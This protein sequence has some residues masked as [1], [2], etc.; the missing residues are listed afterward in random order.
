MGVKQ[1][2]RQASYI[3]MDTDSFSNQI[4]EIFDAS[5]EQPV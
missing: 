2:I 4:P 3:V 1:Q 5:E